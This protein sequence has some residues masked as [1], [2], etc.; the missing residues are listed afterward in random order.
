MGLLKLVNPW[1]D[2][3]IWDKELGNIE[4]AWKVL[5]QSIKSQHQSIARVGA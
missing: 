2:I 1:L 4:V 3:C 5:E